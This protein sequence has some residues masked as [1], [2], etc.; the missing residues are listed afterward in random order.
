VEERDLKMPEIKAQEEKKCPLS[1]VNWVMFLS[2]EI[3]LLETL[4]ATLTAIVIAVLFVFVACVVTTI[5]SNLSPSFKIGASLFLVFLYVVLA[6]YSKKYL[7]GPDHVKK[8]LEDLRIE[9]IKANWL[10]LMKYAESG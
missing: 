9:V 10:I 2:G 4:R 5:C 3:N 8:K 7:R 1:R 6:W